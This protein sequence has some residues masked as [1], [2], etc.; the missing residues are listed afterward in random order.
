ME[1]TVEEERR[2]LV[3][4]FRHVPT[5]WLAFACR[6]ASP[7]WRAALQ[8][9][10]A[11][12]R[13]WRPR[14]RALGV[15]DGAETAVHHCVVACR[16]ALQRWS[17]EQALRAWRIDYARLSEP[18]VHY[19]ADEADRQLDTGPTCVDAEQMFE[20]ARAARDD[21]CSRVVEDAADY[22]AEQ[23]QMQ[24][25][26]EIAQHLDCLAAILPNDVRF[27]DDIWND[28]RKCRDTDPL[29]LYEAEAGR[30][31]C[32]R[33]RLLRCTDDT[34][35]S[36]VHETPRVVAFGPPN[37]IETRTPTNDVVY[38]RVYTFATQ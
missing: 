14:C 38:Y 24:R 25:D 22:A 16:A 12:E 13:V 19:W 30:T 26:H 4:L 3:D 28:V 32:L 20:M 37:L 17:L 11:V 18:L 35:D 8:C 9:P 21:M 33:G 5:R 1:P 23:L 36:I 15:D 34:D 2:L 10:D 6:Y 27:N 7:S 29:T 31:G